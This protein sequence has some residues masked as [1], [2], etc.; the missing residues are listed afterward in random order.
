MSPRGVK[1]QCG[2]RQQHHSGNVKDPKLALRPHGIEIACWR[3][4]NRDGPMELSD[5]ITG[6]WAEPL[7][8]A[9]FLPFGRVIA[10]IADGAPDDVVD[11]P[12]E[13]SEGT[14]RF[15]SMQPDPR[16]FTPLRLTSAGA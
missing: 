15:Y 11:R 4:H 2:P 9:A 8:E 7:T 6:F 3:Q 1:F 5:S 16:V 12:L 10:A 13:L 14:P